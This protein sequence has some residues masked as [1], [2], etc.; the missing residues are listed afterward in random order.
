M[1]DTTSGPVIFCKNYD[2]KIMTQSFNLLFAYHTVSCALT[3]EMSP[4]FCIPDVAHMGFS[5][6]VYG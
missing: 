5:G 2:L 3:A 4:T 1:L 6:L